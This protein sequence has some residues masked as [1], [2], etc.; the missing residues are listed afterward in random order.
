VARPDEPSS[1]GHGHDEVVD[2]RVRGTGHFVGA[3][4]TVNHD[5][6]HVQNCD[7]RERNVASDANGTPS[8]TTRSPSGARTR[9]ATAAPMWSY[10]VAL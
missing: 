1:P 2:T 9:S 10:A 8:P 3:T 5:L 6:F 7:D 4:V